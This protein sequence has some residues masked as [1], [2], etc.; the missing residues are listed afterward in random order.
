MEFTENPY[1]FNHFID[2]PFS[3][4]LDNEIP[5][6]IFEEIMNDINSNALA[7]DSISSVDSGRSSTS[8][9]DNA[10]PPVASPDQ[11]VTEIAAPKDEP[12]LE[13]FDDTTIDASAMPILQVVE[14]T[15]PVIKTEQATITTIQQP[16]LVITHPK[17]LVKNEPIA[18]QSH[19]NNVNVLTLQNIGGQ[20]YTTMTNGHQSTIHNVVN[21]QGMH[22]HIFLSRQLQ[23]KLK[24]A[25]IYAL[26]CFFFQKL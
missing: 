9:D 12:M 6:D 18:F 20:L 14:V 23:K 17:I 10:S 24:T 19:P 16:Q 21:R 15:Q 2:T 1:T 22:L 26:C 8:Y 11:M 25:R 4:L 5:Q 7:M 13:L 3:N